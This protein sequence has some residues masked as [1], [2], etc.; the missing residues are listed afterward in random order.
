MP[1]SGGRKK[2]GLRGRAKTVGR[3]KIGL[4]NPQ[5]IGE[6]NAASTSGEFETSAL[7]LRLSAAGY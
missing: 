7:R 4:F 1:G 3:V 2:N 6:Q 5:P